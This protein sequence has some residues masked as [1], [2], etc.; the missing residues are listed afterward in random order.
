VYTWLARTYQERDPELFFIFTDPEF[1]GMR[2][3]ARFQELV[4]R[5]EKQ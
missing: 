4:R 3:E 5:I 2:G 1:G